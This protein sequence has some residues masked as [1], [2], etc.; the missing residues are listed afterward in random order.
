MLKRILAGFIVVI[1]LVSATIAGPFE[2][3]VAADKHG[4]YVEAAKSYRLAADQGHAK[5]QFNLG[6]MYATGLGVPQD[7]VEAMKCFRLAAR[8]R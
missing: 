5:A 2:D 6:H 1:M 7:Y 3:G 8:P 4:D